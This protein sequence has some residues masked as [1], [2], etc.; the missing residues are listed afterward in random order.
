MG[1][2]TFFGGVEQEIETTGLLPNFHRAISDLQEFD[3]SDDAHLIQRDLPQILADHGLPTEFGDAIFEQAKNPEHAVK[4]AERTA[5][6]LKH[7]KQMDSMSGLRALS[8]G[9]AGFGGDPTN[10]V[11]GFAL[12]KGAV[13][14]GKFVSKLAPRV[15]ALTSKS[16]T[17]RVAAWTAFGAVEE[18]FRN[19]PRLYN[20]PTYTYEQYMLD[21]AIGAGFTGG[22]AAGIPAAKF[23]AQGRFRHVAEA[24]RGL[25]TKLYESATLRT[26]LNMAWAA[27][28]GTG[29]AVKDDGVIGMLRKGDIGAGIRNARNKANMQVA[30][31]RTLNSINGAARNAAE[32]FKAESDTAV[33]GFDKSLKEILDVYAPTGSANRA[34]VQ[35]FTDWADAR[36]AA[37][38]QKADTAVD[39][40]KQQTGTQRKADTTEDKIKTEIDSIQQSVTEQVAD[41]D[42]VT[43]QALEA[44]GE[45]TDK[46]S[47]QARLGVE[48]S[49]MAAK[50]AIEA[51]AARKGHKVIRKALRDE[52]VDA[53]VQ[54]RFQDTLDSHKKTGRKIEDLLKQRG[55]HLAKGE[56]EATIKEALE[57]LG[58]RTRALVDIE[59]FEKNVG[60]VID[61][62]EE[63]VKFIKPEEGRTAV[64][65]YVRENITKALNNLSEKIEDLHIGNP[66]DREFLEAKRLLRDMQDEMESIVDWAGMLQDKTYSDLTK[67][68]ARWALLSD[69]YEVSM[70]AAGREALSEAYEKLSQRFISKQFGA[71]TQSL[72][73]RLVRTKVPLAEWMA[74]NILELPAG[75]GG[76]I[77]RNET[78][79]ITA[80]M[81]EAD[82]VVPLNKAWFNMMDEAA[83]ELGLGRFRRAILRTAGGNTHPIVKQINRDLM[84]YVNAKQMGRQADAPEYIKK[85]AAKMEEANDKMYDLQLEH[86]LDG[87]TGHNKMKNY[88]KQAWNDGA[89]LDMYNDPNIGRSGVVQ[90]FTKSLKSRAG[91]KLTM[92]DA[93]DIAEAVLDT[94]LAAMNK[95][96]VD[97]ARLRSNNLASS[98]AAL[99]DIVAK[100][101][102]SKKTNAVEAIMKW[103]KETDG[104]G[105][106]YVNKRFINLDYST[107][108]NLNGTTVSMLDLLD[109]D[110]IGGLNRYAKE[111][112]GRSAISKASGGR[113]N[114]E[115]A[116]NDFIG[117]VG[118]QAADM[119]TY[120]NTNDIRNV[121]RQMM[122][123]PYDGQLPLNVRKIRDAVSL[124]GMNGL[125]E[126]QL[127]EFGLAAN[128]GLSGLFAMNQ[129]ASKTVGKIKQWRHMELTESQ[130]KNT[131]FLGELQEAAKLYEDMHIVARNNVHFDAR[132]PTMAAGAISKLIETGTGGKYRPTLQYLQSRWTGYGQ[133]RTMEEQVA[134]AGLIQDA[135]KLIRGDKSF[136]TEARFKDVGLDLRLLKGKLDDGTISLDKNGNVETLNLHRWSEAERHTLGVALRRHSAQQVQ[137]GFAGEMSPLMTDP[138]VAMM[139]QF[140]AYPMLAAE[141]QMGRNAMFADKEAGMGIALNAASSAAARMI[142][143]YSLAAA[144]P[145][146]KRERYLEQKMSNDFGHDTIQYMGIVGMMVNN[147]DTAAS[148]GWGDASVGDQFPAISW[149]DNYI[150]GVKSVNP[151]GGFDERDV[152]NMQRGAPIGTIMWVNLIAGVIRNLMETDTEATYEDRK[153][154]GS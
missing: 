14:T 63:F 16:K 5:R 15:A 105:P 35:R 81:M 80:Q 146:D 141:K 95:P 87:I 96:S 84:K 52:T 101:N 50:R 142:R 138:R 139:M 74:L 90:L 150:N 132:E 7:S 27:T 123:L 97:P 122:G 42:I 2:P 152:A 36:A 45:G 104:G 82:I 113:L 120:V 98:M 33:A 137:I 28:K 1:L 118:T 135:M 83:L 153:T 6:V 127:A 110:V 58:I 19:S 61:E 21:V 116:I 51:A 109:N 119:G 29:R 65:Q 99:E 49:A 144:L 11:P 53:R 48:A 41:V 54:K 129:L 67:L 107:E 69:E 72:S 79:A 154:R 121:F 34:N 68:D 26:G 93:K 39:K 111:A 136:T 55:V 112:T 47:Q 89:I 128:R 23:L 13:A 37:A 3:E 131:K 125:G 75:T 24:T 115:T 92:Q 73:A 133:V 20:D 64:V 9:I 147:Y 102:G 149:A 94:K 148:L 22:I 43:K 71:L 126:S 66:A 70:G 12:Y 88:M 124:A 46:A 59:D 56:V 32:K 143:Y 114:S 145:S 4:L 40:T 60:K 86:N 77:A 103:T 134:M 76:K 151:V 100:L 106:G 18:S 62:G 31:S 130:K 117:A 30:E 17:G 8:T 44:I 10:L 25:H 108:I 91:E 57:E 85:F 140:R 78:A 38:V